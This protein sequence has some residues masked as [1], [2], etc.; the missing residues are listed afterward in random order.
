MRALLAELDLSHRRATTSAPKLPEGV[1]K[2]EL[3][4]IYLARLASLVRTQLIPGYLVV[5]ADETNL[6]L[7]P[8]RDTTLEVKGAKNVQI[9]GHGALLSVLFYFLLTPFF[10]RQA[11]GHG[12]DRRELAGRRSPGP[13]HFR[14][15]DRG[16]GAR[17]RI[18]LHRQDLH[19]A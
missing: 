4:E 18:G 10:R 11:A 19:G 9:L 5:F 2:D 12:H 13:D 3:R 14:G 17:K 1:T 8:S 16:R 7:V 15:P 6:F